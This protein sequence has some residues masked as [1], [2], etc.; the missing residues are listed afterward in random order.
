MPELL[1]LKDR[2]KLF[3]KEIEQQTIPEPKKDRK[4]SFLSEDE[5]SKMKEEEAARIASMTRMDLETLDSLTSQLS[6][7]DDTDTVLE[8]VEEISRVGPSEISLPTEEGEGE[9]DQQLKRDNRSV[10]RKERL[11]SLEEDTEQAQQIVERIAELSVNYTGEDNATYLL[12]TDAMGNNVEAAARE[13]SSAPAREENSAPA[14]D[15]SPAPARDESPAPARDES[16]APGGVADP[17]TETDTEETTER[18]LTSED[19]N[20]GPNSPSSQAE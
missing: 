4:F 19:Q 9:E 6:Q 17:D 2:L 8:Q 3:E 14:R 10:W 5:L 20:T 1:S 16:P 18:M 15:E 11:R 13:G 7:E 12:P